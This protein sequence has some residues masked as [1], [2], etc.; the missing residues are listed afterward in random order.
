MQL[1]H[2]TWSSS[3]LLRQRF[4]LRGG[5]LDT[6]RYGESPDGVMKS[7]QLAG[8]VTMVNSWYCK[9]LAIGDLSPDSPHQPLRSVED[10][11]ELP[12]ADAFLKRASSR[13]RISQAWWGAHVPSPCTSR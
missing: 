13:Y 12:S 2:S 10:T 6:S 1:A 3:Q 5:R 8:N 9:Y 11:A 7:D 4:D